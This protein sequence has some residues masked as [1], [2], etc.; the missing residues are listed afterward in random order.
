MGLFK[1]KPNYSEIGRNGTTDQFSQAIA[2]KKTD[3]G[4]YY[5][6]DTRD[7]VDGAILAFREGRTANVQTALANAEALKS[8]HYRQPVPAILLKLS[9]GRDDKQAAISLALET[10]SADEKQKLVNDALNDAIVNGIGG[11]PFFALL[12]ESGA[13]ANA[14]INGHAGNIL[15]SA[16]HYKSPISVIKLLHEKGASFDDALDTMHSRGYQTADIDRLKHYQERMV[17]KP[18]TAGEASCPPSMDQ[19]MQKVLETMMHMQD[20]IT[21]LTE[22]LDRLTAPV[23]AANENQPEKGKTAP[24]PPAKKYPGV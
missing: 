1:S 21:E 23:P 18:A 24:K 10:F 6:A 16:T 2:K 20:Q 5:D 9:E 17:G 13:Q 14:E 11:E 7:L 22:K 15:V 12:L 3:P 4:Y 8:Y 19:A